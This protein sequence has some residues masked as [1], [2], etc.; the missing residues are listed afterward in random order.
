MLSKRRR[1]KGGPFHVRGT[2]KVGAETRIVAEHS[3]GIDSPAIADAYIRKLERQIQEEVLYGRAGRARHLTF[4]D[5]AKVYLLRPEGLHPNDAWRLNEL[6]EIMGNYAIADT[7]DGWAAFRE[8]RCSGLAPSTV[9]RFRAVLVAALRYAAPHLSYDPP[10][11]PAIRY[12][13]ERVRWLPFNQAE[14]LVSSYVAHVRPIALTLRFQ[15]C[16]TQEA[17]QLQIPNVDLARGTMFFE[18][19][20]N[21]QPRTVA[22]HERVWDAIGGLLQARDNPEL[23]HVF[24]NRF[25]RPYADTRDYKLPGG[26]PLSKAHGTAV[27]RAKVR[28]NGGDDFRVHDWRHHWAC[29]MVMGGADLETLR[30]L[31]GWKDFRSVMRYAAVS[32]EHMHA[33][34]ARQK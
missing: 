1:K 24:L 25:G 8:K 17:L 31:G 20:K 6:N 9:D 29:T 32:D 4:S 14:R 11:V 3:T 2:V 10:T 30:R 7:I 23:G 27:R 19:T 15:G 18:R 22:M 34:I 26:N 12:T 16:R 33:A 5:A 28:P 13:N 21:G